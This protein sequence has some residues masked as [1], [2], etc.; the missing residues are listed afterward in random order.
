MKT[1]QHHYESEVYLLLFV[2]HAAVN[3]KALLSFLCLKGQLGLCSIYK[4]T[5]FPYLDE[6][7]FICTKY[8]YILVNN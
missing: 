2:R 8:R 7:Q 4:I 5:L 3:V 6:V 1:K